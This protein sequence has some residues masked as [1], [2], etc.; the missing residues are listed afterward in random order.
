MFELTARDMVSNTPSNTP[1]SM[2]NSR[3][4]I[5]L[6][7]EPTLMGPRIQLSSLLSKVALCLKCLKLCKSK[8]KANFLF[9]SWA[10]LISAG[11]LE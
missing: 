7:Y 9:S 6:Y 5:S 8:P 4:N 1:V 11:D 2:D 10:E 3:Q